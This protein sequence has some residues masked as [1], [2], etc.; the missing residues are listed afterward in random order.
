MIIS[1]PFWMNAKEMRPVHH[2][3][4]LTS[5]LIFYGMWTKEKLGM[6]MLEL[7]LIQVYMMSM[8]MD[9]FCFYECLHYHIKKKRKKKRETFLLFLKFF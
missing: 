5:A 3:D 8:T 7:S 4:E 1:T 9:Y 6:C 2:S